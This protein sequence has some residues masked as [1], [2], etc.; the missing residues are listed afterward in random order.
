[1]CALHLFEW[2]SVVNGLFAWLNFTSRI[3][4][5]RSYLVLLESGTTASRA[6]LQEILD[7]TEID[8]VFFKPIHRFC[9]SSLI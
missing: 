6:Q 8:L 2:K 1:L 5:K 3:G 4:C 7:V 9:Y